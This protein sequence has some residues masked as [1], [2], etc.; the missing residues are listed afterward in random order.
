MNANLPN[1][2]FEADWKLQYILLALF[3]AALFLPF[4]GHVHLFDWDEANFAEITREMLVTGEYFKVQVDYQPF[5]EKPPLFA[6]VQAVNFKVFGIN[7]FAARFPNVVV[8]ILCLITLY[9]VGSRIKDNKF[10]LIW[11]LCYSGSLLPFFFFKTGLI[12]PIFNLLIFI[13]IIYLIQLINQENSVWYKYLIAGM[14]NGAAI[15]AKG[16]VALLILMLVGFSYWILIHRKLKFIAFKNIILIGLGVLLT[17]SLWFIPETIIRGPAFI[18]EFIYYMIGLLSRDIA[19]HAQPFYYHTIVIYFGCFPI[20]V[21]ALKNIIKTQNEKYDFNRWMICLF[22]VVLILF[23]IVK[24]KIVNYSSLTYYPLSY[25]AAYTLYQ[26][27][28]DGKI[29]GK[30]VFLILGVIL[31]CIPI[32]FPILFSD[33]DFVQS[34]FKND[35]FS[36]EAFY[37]I[38]FSNWNSIPGLIWLVGI[39][40]AYILL[41]KRKLLSALFIYT[42]TVCIFLNSSLYW[43]IPKIE[44]ALQ[45]PAISYFQELK[46]K[47]VYL[48]TLGFKSY[49]KFFYSERPKELSG[50]SDKELLKEHH[51]KDCYLVVKPRKLELMKQHPEFKQIDQKGGFYLFLRAKKE[52]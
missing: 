51:D 4:I 7:E 17:S 5:Y 44:T 41:S 27:F 10:G 46:G 34:I 29:K 19:S 33:Q 45:G 14:I 15:L 22:W 6:W 39:I 50:Y 3:G 43:V 8:G 30:S 49:A 38:Q 52:Q 16:P 20:S 32:L 35:R 1:K 31:S 48:G 2:F 28:E 25:L 42:V 23:S 36:R 37:S 47:D 40:I 24:T 18:S 21:F 26:Y 11:V 13:S 12:D 9:F